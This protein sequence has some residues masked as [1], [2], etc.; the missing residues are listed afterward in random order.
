METSVVGASGEPA[1]S[2]RS[3]RGLDWLNFFMADV[4][5]GVGPFLAAALVTRRWNPEQIGFVLAAGGMAG[6]ILQ[7]PAGATV[8]AVHQKRALITACVGVMVGSA[9]MLA[10]SGRFAVVLTAQILLGAAGPFIAPALAA[11]TLGLV[12]KRLFDIRF[13]RNQSFNSAGNVFAALLMGVVGWRFGSQDIFYCVPFLAIP[14]LITLFVIRPEEIDYLRARGA[15]SD[16]N[17]ANISGLQVLFKDRVLLAFA[18]AAILFHLANA[19]M[20]P[21]LGEMLSKG[22]PKSAAVFMSAAVTVTQIVIACSATWVGKRARDWGRKPLL[23]VGF[24]VLPIRGLLYTLTTSVPLLISIQLLDGVA[25][26]IFVVVFVLV[27]ADRTRGTGRMNLALGSLGMA[28]GIGASLSTIVAGAIA[29]HVGYA[30]SFLALAGIAV[31]AAT[32]LFFAVPETRDRAVQFASMAS[33]T[34]LSN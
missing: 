20:L 23:L 5:T 17:A 24:G 11:I 12:G 25:N 8:D 19:A 22:R 18:V 29:Q 9:L 31:I 33:S 21:Q 27:V 10:W 1:P 32:I 3:L 6:I 16:D 4:Q 14:T 34:I 26:S 15:R 13:G 7:S 2:R 30:A 28:V